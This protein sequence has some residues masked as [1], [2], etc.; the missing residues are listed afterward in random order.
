[1]LGHKTALSGLL[2]VSARLISRVIDLAT[3]LILAR[4]LAPADFGFVAIAMTVILIIEAAL[5]L[6]LSEALVR[7]PV[8]MESYYDTAFT[9]GLAR[10]VVL[11]GGV[12]A[13]AVPFADFYHQP[14]LVLLTCALSIAPSVRGLRNPRLAQYAKDLNFKWEF[15]FEL[16]GKV[17]AFALGAACAITF[18]SYWSLAVCTITAPLV[19]MV[20]SYLVLPFRPKLSL[21]NWR[22]F[23]GFLGWISLSQVV[24]ALN[25]QSDQLLLG[26]I[27]HPTEYGLFTTANTLSSI[28]MLA[29]FSP[30]LRPLL[31]AFAVLK[32]VPDRLRNSYQSAAG[33]IVAVGLPLLVGQSLVA[34]PTVHL[35]LGNK[36]LGAIPMLH[37]LALSLVPALFGVLVTPLGMAL[38]ETKELFWRSVF[39]MCIKLPLVV[40]GALMFGF[41]GIIGA[42]LISETV[43]AIYCMTIVRR[44]V[45]A[46]VLSQLTYCWRSIAA[47][48]VMASVLQLARPWLDQSVGMSMLMQLAVKV[49]LGASSYCGAT[50]ILWTVTGK[51][52]GVETMI[53]S[54]I[55]RLRI[56]SRPATAHPE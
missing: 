21:T 39:Q 3:I 28:V 54:A 46:P 10:A 1:V 55:A 32:T 34:G 22:L 36:W 49:A 51:P 14:K 41:I 17:A 8:I 42:R 35:L 48:I 11:C 26:K 7:L 50:A 52:P 37:W 19:T 40:A 2:M 20:L 18:R 38:N 4:F 45:G 47:T 6:P 23:S 29:L 5:E 15:L 24:I 13:I 12:C 43:T 33:G 56:V 31:S 25:W 44:L 27:M 9:L 30:V 16:A 53:T